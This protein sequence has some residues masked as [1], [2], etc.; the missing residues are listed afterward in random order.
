MKL[1]RIISGGFLVVLGI[2]GIILP[3]MPGWIFLIP[4]LIILAEYFPWAQRLLSYARR[5]M[6][7]A[8]EMAGARKK[9]AETQ[10]KP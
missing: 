7:Q 4:G 10:S 3:V 2:A 5:K 1:F 9:P 6:E 8:Q